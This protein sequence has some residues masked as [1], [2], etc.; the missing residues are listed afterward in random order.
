[1][2]LNLPFAVITRN[3][4]PQIET[5]IHKARGRTRMF[6]FFGYTAYDTIHCFSS[7]LLYCTED[8]RM[9]DHAMPK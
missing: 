5:R 3:V 1:M 8:I 7:G 4:E 2:S 6:L 9:A